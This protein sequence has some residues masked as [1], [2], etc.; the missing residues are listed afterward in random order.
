MM[1]TTQ[2]KQPQAEGGC[3][4]HHEEF[5]LWFKEPKKI[6]LS[7]NKMGAAQVRNEHQLLQTIGKLN[8]E[9]RY[10]LG[11]IQQDI[12]NLRFRQRVID[13]DKRKRAMKRF[14]KAN[15]HRDLTMDIEMVN[16]SIKVSQECH[17][18][19]GLPLSDRYIE[20]K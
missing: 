20:F 12:I 10:E 3:S 15:P 1:T 19:R 7:E 11:K 17:E 4:K 5:G 18:G 14:Q 16:K 8:T 13:T 9:H 6:Q 2:P